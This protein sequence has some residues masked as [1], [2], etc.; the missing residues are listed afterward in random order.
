MIQIR[1]NVFET[2]SSSTHSIAIPR[3]HAKKYPNVIHFGIGEFGWGF[4]EENPADYLYT[5][6]LDY[7]H[8]TEEREAKLAELKAALDAY[9][10]RYTMQEPKFEVYSED[11]SKTYLNWDCGFIDHSEDLGEFLNAVF[12]NAETLLDFAF[13]GLVFTGNDN[14]DAEERAFTFRDTPT[15]IDSHYNGKDKKWVDEEITNPYYQKEYDNY[16][17]YVKLN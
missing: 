6:I 10:I 14:S 9:D 15:Y 2:N 16:D 8:N 4:A 13:Y 3:E 17:W 1:R 11:P 5:A 7:Y 12:A